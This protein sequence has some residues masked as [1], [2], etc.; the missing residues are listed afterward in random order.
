MRAKSTMAV[1][2]LSAAAIAFCMTAAPAKAGDDDKD[3]D[4]DARHARAFERIATFTIVNNDPGAERT[5]ERVAEILDAT[6]DGKTLVYAD[7]EGEQLGFLDI[8]DPANP[9][10]L[11]TVPV[12]GEPTAV[13]VAG[14]YALVGVNT[15]PD[16][17]NPSG[18]LAVFDISNPSAPLE[19]ARLD[20]GGQPDSVAVSPDGR[21]AAV[22]IE[23]ER[24]EDLESPLL[25]PEEGGLPQ[26]PAGFLNVVRLKGAPANWTIR[27][28]D[29]TGLADF[30][31]EDPEPEFVDIN[32]RNIAAVSLQENNHIVLV[33]LRRAKVIRDFG[34]GAVTLENVDGVE[35]DVIRLV[36]TLN[37]VPREPD[38]VAWIGRR[39]LATANE[40]DLFG[41]SRGFS[42]FSTRGKVRFDSGSDFDQLAV[43]LGH[44]PEDRSENKGSEPEGVE[45]GEFRG[46]DILFVGAER[47]GFIAVYELRGSRK[48]KLLQAL[49]TGIGPEGLKAIP[50]RGLFVVAAEVDD[51]PS[52]L[53]RK[54]NFRSVI[55]IY[56]LRKGKPSYPTIVSA[57]EDG[58]GGG[59]GKSDGDKDK[60]KDRDARRGGVPI[61]WGALSALAAD[62][63]DGDLLFTAHDSFYKESRI[64]TVDV[65]RDPAVITG[66][67]VLMKNGATINRDLE[68]LVQRANGGFWAV[69]EGNGS[70]DDPSRPVASPNLLIEI[71]PDG[72]V[73]DEVQLPDSVNALQ[74][75]FGFEGVAVTGSGASERVLVAFQREWVGDPA[76]RV[77][78]GVYNPNDGSWRFVYYPIETSGSGFVNAWVG[79]SEIVSLGGDKFAVIERD[80]LIGEEAEI[81]RL[82]TVSLAGVTPKTQDEGG[83][84]TLSKTLAFDVLPVMQARNGIV[85]DKLE[86]LTVAADGEVYVVT[87]NDGVDDSPGETQFLRLGEAE[88][89]F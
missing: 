12:G 73:L 42:I 74:R 70:V 30:A 8:S 87:D 84:E 28:V 77:R 11:G 68:G 75:R 36:D 85:L 20:M 69:S 3:K 78:I 48:A 49:P 6:A 39:Y 13:S 54:A 57:N 55:S 9:V 4:G 14:R 5:D 60:D 43:R 37:D 26:S 58:L 53:D 50:K 72:T 67:I 62:R 46:R 89:V 35:D 15:S 80:N 33:D 86:G 18:E 16:F 40:G 47:S 22:V 29:L 44:Y 25:T 76:N 52:A 38:A 1:R 83:F 65:G 24:D 32:E 82:Y 7:S 34:A 41:G 59:L 31:P 10:G 88:E 45:Y 66:Q 64:Y 27:K 21:Y 56:K 71:A 79:L 61:A 19:V 23:N 2:L 81:K 51:P 63:E 17:V